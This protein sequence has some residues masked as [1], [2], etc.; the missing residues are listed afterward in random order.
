VSVKRNQFK[1]AAVAKLLLYIWIYIYCISWDSKCGDIRNWVIQRA[2]L[3]QKLINRLLH[4]TMPTRWSPNCQAGGWWAK[5]TL[6]NQTEIKKRN[7]VTMMLPNI[8]HELLLY[9]HQ[10]SQLADNSK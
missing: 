7:I 9:C 5:A 10:P 2:L 3:T 1:Q 8:L 4:Y 6:P